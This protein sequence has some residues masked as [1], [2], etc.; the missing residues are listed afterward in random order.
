MIG[1]SVLGLLFLAL[2]SDLWVW[3]S[4][5]GGIVTLETLSE[6]KIILVPGASV[7]R[8]G[9]PSPVLRQRM[10]TA[11]EASKIWPEARLVLSG[12]AIRGGYDEPLAMRNY[13]REHGVELARMQFD[14]EGRNTRASIWNL[15]PPSGELVVV[16]QRWHLS[17]A[18]WLARQR[19]W[20]V[21][22]LVAGKGTPAGW[23]NLLREH[24]VRVEN[25][26]ERILI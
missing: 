6:A 22:G 17:R 24:V 10:E 26:W 15:G 21:Q 3:W 7:L 16:S 9:R 5:S 25:F 14:R 19:G 23:E 20:R 4:G 12:S 8:S 2:G 11:L 18:V 1:T 13:L